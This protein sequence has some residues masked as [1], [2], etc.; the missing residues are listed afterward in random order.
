[1]SKKEDISIE[2]KTTESNNSKVKNLMS[3]NFSIVL[4]IPIGDTR[5][6]DINSFFDFVVS[7]FYVR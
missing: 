4:N 3:K 1:M 6:K 2:D 7:I 5:F